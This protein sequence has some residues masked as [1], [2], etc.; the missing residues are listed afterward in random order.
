MRCRRS[1]TRSSATPHKL[2]RPNKASQRILSPSAS[3]TTLCLATHSPSPR[4]V[5]AAETSTRDAASACWDVGAVGRELGM[6]GLDGTTAAVSTRSAGPATIRPTMA[7]LRERAARRR[8]TARC[9]SFLWVCSPAS[10]NTSGRSDSAASLM[11]PHRHR[12]ASRE[13][14]SASTCASAGA[15]QP[16]MASV[17]SI[18]AIRCFSSSFTS[19][20]AISPTTALLI[21]GG[22]APNCP[23]SWFSAGTNE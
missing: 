17:F 18:V 14:L 10:A 12:A 11:I 21:S 22:P 2:A 16:S 23:S 13:A 4:P 7:G 1:S 9:T 6:A 19:A 15:C 5:I 20:H 8:I 3:S